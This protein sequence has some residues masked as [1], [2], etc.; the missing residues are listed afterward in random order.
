MKLNPH[1]TGLSIGLFF[2]GAH[3][4]W[5]LLIALGLAQTLMTWSLTW[6][7]INSPMT[8]APFSLTNAV[9]LVIV[10]GIVGYGFGY[11]FSTIWNQVHK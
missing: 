1:K 2:A 9:T 10:T 5:S 4:L 3:L 7:M 11:A 8:V 6:H